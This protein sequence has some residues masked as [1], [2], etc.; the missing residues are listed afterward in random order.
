MEFQIHLMF[1]AGITLL[2]VLNPFGNLTQF[3]AMS[4]GLSLKLRKKL[5]RT[6]LYT[7]FAIVLIFLLSG[8][9]F[10]NYIFRVSLDD[11]R[12]S[13]GLVLII[14]AIKNLLFSTKIAMKDFSNYQNMDE[15][16]LLRQ[17]LIPMAF[18]MLVG[19]GTLASVI[20]ISED[21]GVD[22]ALGGIVIAFIFMFILFH[23]AA[24]IEKIVGK[25]I[26]HIF[27]RIAQVF[28]VAMGIKMVITGLKDIF[29][30]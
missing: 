12:I 25:L 18:P 5:F 23:F 7:A 21:K 4:D 10:M 30:L 17:S 15:E 28:I 2:A 19:P 22:I 6:I 20:V 27:S 16:E 24:T 26:L 8:P 3:L 1:F 14:M 11:L 29:N 9:L 13:G